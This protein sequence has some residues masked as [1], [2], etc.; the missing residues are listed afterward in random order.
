MERG[1]RLTIV[2]ASI[3]CA[4]FL[5]AGIFAGLAPAQEP[6]GKDD[7]PEDRLLRAQLLEVSTGD[8]EKAKT[9]YQA[10]QGDEKAAESTRALALLYLARCHRKLGEIDS[11]RKV[12]DEL[13]KT[14]EKQRDVIRQARSFLRE[15]TS[16]K[17][18]SPDFDW[19]KELE[20]SPEIQAR[21]FDLAMDLTERPSDAGNRAWR[22]LLALGTIGIP[23]IE[24]VLESTRSPTH[25]QQLAL[26][27]VRLGR[28]EKLPVVLDPRQPPRGGQFLADDL[29]SLQGMVLTMDE[30]ERARLRVELE[31]L[32]PA[33]GI[34]PYRDALLLAA[35][36]RSGLAEKLASM[37][38]I[39]SSFMRAELLER[40]LK[41]DQSAVDVLL[42]RILDPGCTFKRHYFDAV[43]GKDPARLD[44]EHWIAAVSPKANDSV[45]KEYIGGIEKRGDYPL[46]VRLASLPGEEHQ[47]TRQHV[48]NYFFLEYVKDWKLAE[49]PAG[50]AAVLRAAVATVPEAGGS[51]RAFAKENDAAIAEFVDALR[52]RDPKLPGR[53]FDAIAEHGEGWVPSPRLIQETEGLLALKDAYVQSIALSILADAP[54]ETPERVFAAIEALLDRLDNRFVRRDAL[55]A[56]FRRFEAGKDIGPRLAQAFI[57]EYERTSREDQQEPAGEPKEVIRPQTKTLRTSR[58]ANPKRA[59]AKPAAWP[60][61]AFLERLN[62]DARKALYP[63][64]VALADSEAGSRFHDVYFRSFTGDSMAAVAPQLARALEAAKTKEIF[65]E[66][67]VHLISDMKPSFPKEDIPRVAAFLRT[68]AL[69]ESIDVEARLKAFF[70]SDEPPFDWFDWEKLL[71]ETD[72]L[73]GN[74]FTFAGVSLGLHYVVNIASDP[75]QK[76]RA[77]PSRLKDW[78]EAKPDAEKEKIYQAALR[79][80]QP[81]VRRF[82]VMAYSTDRPGA[83]DLLRRALS[84][85]DYSVSN[86]AIEQLKR[87]TR[88]DLAPLAVEL[89]KN[90]DRWMRLGAIELQKRFLSPEAIEPLAALLND[91]DVEVRGKAL[92]ALR[93]V[94]KALH[95][96]NEWELIG[97]GLRPSP[98]PPQKK[99]TGDN[100]APKK[101]L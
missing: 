27:L 24:K 11:A 76:R 22:Q 15:L 14:H 88:G 64:I 80:P 41:E 1:S 82:A 63:H 3:L 78:I 6:G 30:A 81:H 51:L 91:A 33:E 7:G 23:V 86:Q 74:I 9:I 16:G 52:N 38:K 60:F 57:A 69:D 32:P 25:R 29:H 93:E 12:L 45:W 21:V 61:P 97:K 54:K 79:S 87:T 101:E 56:L 39:S 18:E 46:L 84:D 34:T 71:G 72:R 35:G 89:L 2:V 26:I 92:E 65:R 49:A 77:L 94:R 85:T 53:Q 58:T 73:A 70:Y 47:K 13:V 17:P 67:A 19:L 75:A 90:P 28:F 68:V 59:P 44:V 99:D 96:K 36:D 55:L 20:K 50:W 43:L 62:L 40:V 10:I 66:S 83:P 31:R 100:D 5:W 37:E 95:E 98:V 4:E 42:G 48:Y 8:V